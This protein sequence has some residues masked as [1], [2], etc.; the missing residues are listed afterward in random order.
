[1]SSA[2]IIRYKGICH[3]Q[4]VYAS[5]VNFT[6]SR[7]VD[8]VDEVWFLEH[9]A[10]YTLGLKQQRNHIID[11]GHIPVV[12]TDRGGDVTYHGPG[13]LMVYLLLDIRRKA[14][15]VKDFVH[16][17]E[18]S[19]IDMLAD[20]GIDAIRREGAP[21]V[22]VDS[23]KIAALGIKVIKGYTY[24]G[25]AINVDLDL[26]PYHGIEPCGYAD[27]K[28]TQMKSFRLQAD[29]RQVSETLLPHLLQQLDY[30][31]QHQSA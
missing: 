20:Y 30:F 23:A 17:L 9:Q 8:T 29:T 28:I 4:P 13:Q 19:V 5:M 16:R 31:V 6:A 11:A 7:N 12:A 14:I 3:Y 21:G 24:H 26:T 2:L 18:Q 10:I 15:G 22:Y 1:M 25:M 27:L